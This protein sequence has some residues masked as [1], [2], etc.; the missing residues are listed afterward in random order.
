VRRGTRSGLFTIVAVHSTL[1]GPAVGGCRMWHYADARTAVRDALRLSRAM[2]Y[3]AAVADLPM[4]GGKGVIMAP[5]PGPPARRGLRA[6]ALRDFGDTVAMAAGAYLT[7]E[8]VGV[9][10][11]DME[12]IALVTP[13]VTGRSRRHGGSGDPSPATALG[14]EAAMRVACE[15]VHGSSSLRGLT[16]AARG[17]RGRARRRAARRHR[18]R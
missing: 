7:A 12:T 5:A 10:S 1:R 3:K 9:S 18:R 6:D 17:A 4:G 11:R 13:H 14:V 2:T 8:D 15:R 16:V